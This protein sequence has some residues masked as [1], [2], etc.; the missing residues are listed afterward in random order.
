MFTRYMKWISAALLLLA[1]FGR[2]SAN[3]QLLLDC[4]VCV[5]GL[6]VVTQAV[7]M[8][9]YFWATGFLIISVLFNPIA[10]V[11]LST[12]WFFLLDMSCLVAFLISLRALKAQPVL[13]IPSITG[14]RRITESL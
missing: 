8:G 3:F 9:K 14:R 2:F 12:R 11:D 5:T 4:A 13:S 1:I 7:R 10:Q 6:L